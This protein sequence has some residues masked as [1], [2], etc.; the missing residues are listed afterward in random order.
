MRALGLITCLSVLALILCCSNSDGRHKRN[1]DKIRIGIVYNVGGKDDHSYNALALLGIER[2]KKEFKTVLVHDV[3]PGS[4][5]SVE[6]AIRAF[7][8]EQYDLIVG[9]G[10]IHKE[11]I[12]LVAIQ[13]P[14]L[15]F[16][17]IDSVASPPNVA[18]LV[19]KSQEGSYLVGMIAAMKS[20]TGIIGFIGGMN[21][22]L[23]QEFQ[24]GF[25]DGAR[26]FNPNIHVLVNYI[27]VTDLSWNDPGKC[28]EIALSQISR[29]ADIIYT[30]AGNSGLGAF[31]AVEGREA[32]FVIGVDSNQNSLKPGN[33]LTS[34]VK[35]IDRAL[36]ETI[37]SEVERN[38][39][40]GI[41][42]Y[43]LSNGGIDYALDEFNESLIS[44]DMRHRLEQAK[45][46]IIKGEVIM[47]RQCSN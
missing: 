36:Y 35:R 6:P 32:V 21:I 22:S 23:I 44:S 34:M 20:R 45:K 13:Y 9:V 40:G 30:A 14:H 18:S 2:A 5:V 10:L 24:T 1:L 31:N 47:K 29:G 43:N 26:S 19:F 7:A 27:G 4:S 8:E 46:R 25:E 42:V 28:S 41:H 15:H 37:S 12:E 38:F 11:I 3:E 17:V 39:T 16:V 33:V